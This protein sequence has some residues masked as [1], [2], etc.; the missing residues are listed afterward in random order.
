MVR[1]NNLRPKTSCKK[2]WAVLLLI[3]ASLAIIAYLVD[4]AEQPLLMELP[5]AALGSTVSTN[6][7][8]S[9]NTPGRPLM[10]EFPVAPLGSTVQYGRQQNCPKEIDGLRFINS[11][12]RKRKTG[13]F[14]WQQSSLNDKWGFY[15]FCKANGIRVPEIYM[16]SSEGPTILID[17]KEPSDRGFVIKI[18]DGKAS[19]GVY[20]LESGFG[21]REQLSGRNMTRRSLMD[22]LQK[23]DSQNF[24]AEEILEGPTTGAVPTDYKF[25]VA[26]GEILMCFVVANRGTDVNCEASVDE[27]FHRVDE[28]G[29][30]T[31]RKRDYVPHTLV[32]GECSVPTNG[33]R[34]FEAYNRCTDFDKPKEWDKLVAMAKKMSRI[35]G[36]FVRIDMYIHRGEVVLGEATFLP[37]FGRYHCFSKLDENGCIDSCL[38]GRFWKRQNDAFHNT[39]GGPIPPEPESI[40]SWKHLSAKEK[41]ERMMEVNIKV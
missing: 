11:R 21:G 10:L 15:V 19:K 27:Q 12:I 31:N 40:K 5:I 1:I 34:P 29:C 33:I 41:C 23:N 22:E 25:I 4:T 30:F 17:W 7:S 13:D 18:K 6:I 39:E 28:H 32:P 2:L 14:P 9:I 16:C 8:Y 20:L 36:I 35:I 3:V 37:W 24:H 26:N 38:M